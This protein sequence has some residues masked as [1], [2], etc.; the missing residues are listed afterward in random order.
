MSLIFDILHSGRRTELTNLAER[1]AGVS[2]FMALA[3]HSNMATLQLYI[4]LRPATLKADVEVGLGFVI[5]ST[6]R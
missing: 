5:T 6:K 1:G 2:V 4:V 3:G